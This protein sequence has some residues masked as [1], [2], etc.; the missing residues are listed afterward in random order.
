MREEIISVYIALFSALFASYTD[1]VIEG[2]NIAQQAHSVTL[3]FMPEVKL[4]MRKPISMYLNAFVCFMTNKENVT[5]VGVP[6]AC[7]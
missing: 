4:L 5:N 6:F 1:F 7:S 3:F 2:V